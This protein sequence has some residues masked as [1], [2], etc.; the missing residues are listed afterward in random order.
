MDKPTKGDKYRCIDPDDP[1]F[2]R[3]YTVFAGPD[4]YPLATMEG[5][6]AATEDD[7]WGIWHYPD[8]FV[9]WEKVTDGTG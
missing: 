7:D 9:G 1:E 5:P 3:V 6:D 4:K 2:G 8:D